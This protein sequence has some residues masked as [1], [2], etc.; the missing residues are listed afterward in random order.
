MADWGQ[1]GCG[2][3]VDGRGLGAVVDEGVG[4]EEAVLARLELLARE[5]APLFVL[6]GDGLEAALPVFALEY[7]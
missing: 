1:A 4:L 6:V 3:G 5:L 2:R 7:G